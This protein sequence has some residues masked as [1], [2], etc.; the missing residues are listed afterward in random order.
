LF[1]V[2][3]KTKEDV[4]KGD[5]SVTT[6][7]TRYGKNTLNPHGRLGCLRDLPSAGLPSSRR[8]SI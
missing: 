6:A 3:G 4:E 7:A 1:S 5:R 8:S 2:D